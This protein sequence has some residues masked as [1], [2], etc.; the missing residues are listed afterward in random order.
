MIRHSLFSVWVVLLFSVSAQAE[1]LIEIYGEA[2]KSDPELAAAEAKRDSVLEL[3]PQSIALLLPSLTASAGA[4][5]IKQHRKSSPFGSSVGTEI[6][7]QNSFSLDLI[8]P[9]YHHDYWVKLSQADSFVAQAEAEYLAARQALIFRSAQ[10][11]FAV[12]SA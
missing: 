1:S 11:Y 5:H 2:L 10:S 9:V 3:K 4:N 6:Y 7:D 8:Q 12:L